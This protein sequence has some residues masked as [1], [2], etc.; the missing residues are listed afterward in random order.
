MRARR[1]ELRL[2]GPSQPRSAMAALAAAAMAAAG[3]GA[4]TTVQ[5]DL[6]GMNHCEQRLCDAAEYE[7]ERVRHCEG[8]AA[9]LELVEDAIT[10]KKLKIREQLLYI[11]LHRVDAAPPSSSSTGLRLSWDG[12]RQAKD[13]AHRLLASRVRHRQGAVDPPPVL[14]SAGPGTGKTWSALQLAH[15]LAVLSGG[16]ES[17]GGFGAFAPVPILIFVQRLSR[18]VRSALQQGKPAG[19][20]DLLR[21]YIE[22]EF[23]QKDPR[24]ELMLKQAMALR[25]LVI[26]IDGVDEASGLEQLIEDFVL[27]TLV[28][29]GFR[30]VVTSRPT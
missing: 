28:P 4:A 18:H 10:G 15:E 13:I 3:G 19:K 5:V 30:L 1:F 14:V 26:V 16:A 17:K 25:S 2:A 8:L 23:S 22:A 11:D 6:N 24:R 9:S 27:K 7:A 12:I 20:D 29:G 21:L